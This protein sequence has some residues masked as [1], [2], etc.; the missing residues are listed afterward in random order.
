M[1]LLP[2]FQLI[3]LRKTKIS[4]VIGQFIR[5]PYI[6]KILGTKIRITKYFLAY[7][8][9]DSLPSNGLLVKSPKR[10]HH[11]PI[12]SKSTDIYIVQTNIHI[13]MKLLAFLIIAK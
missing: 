9:S 11:N 8:I 5:G 2:H 6:F 10:T 1:N 13:F 12:N 4:P 3:D 7:F